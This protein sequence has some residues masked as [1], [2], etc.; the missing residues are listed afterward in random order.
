MAASSVEWHDQHCH[1]GEGQRGQAQLTGRLFVPIDQAQLF[2]LCLAATNKVVVCGQG[3]DHGFGRDRVLQQAFNHVAIQRGHLRQGVNG[4]FPGL[5]GV[6][7]EGGNE[8]AVAG[9]VWQVH[10]PLCD[11]GVV[12]TPEPFVRDVCV[13]SRTRRA[14]G[15]R[16]TGAGHL[17]SVGLIVLGVD[18]RV[19]DVDGVGDL[20]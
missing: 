19:D 4:F 12:V 8:D 14:S 20:V 11:F 7:D 10:M 13:H 17:A 1:P 3:L 16:E 5:V 18:E 6:V 9:T 2:Q 15:L